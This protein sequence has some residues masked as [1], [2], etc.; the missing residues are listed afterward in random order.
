MTIFTIAL[1][2]T[3][4]RNGFTT[5]RNGRRKSFVRNQI[6]GRNEFTMENIRKT[7][8][9]LH[10]KVKTEQKCQ[11]NGTKMNDKPFRRETRKE[12]FTVRMKETPAYWHKICSMAIG[13]CNWRMIASRKIAR[14]KSFSCVAQISVER[15]TRF[16][17]SQS[18]RN[19]VVIK[20][21]FKFHC[22][23]ICA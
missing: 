2:N 4:L 22:M 16:R 5:S 19:R 12:Q 1:I 14:R 13:L 23:Q 8:E 6:D 21:Q 9:K 17:P 20:F 10:K 18:N 3:M 15:S 11:E 7:R